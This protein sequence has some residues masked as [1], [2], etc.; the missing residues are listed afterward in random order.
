MGILK[1]DTQEK[2]LLQS[3]HQKSTLQRSI[4]QRDTIRR[5][6]HPR[7]TTRRSTP[8]KV[9]TMEMVG[10]NMADTTERITIKSQP[11]T[12]T[13]LTTGTEAHTNTS[14]DTV[15]LDTEDIEEEEA[16]EDTAE[17]MAKDTAEDTDHSMMSLMSLLH[18]FKF[19]L[20]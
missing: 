12:D 18:S 6:I 19:E 13:N 1:Q 4:H 11:I 10:I 9:G 15:D 17:D 3:T 5:S 14:I 7:S 16:T 8:P 2:H 20:M